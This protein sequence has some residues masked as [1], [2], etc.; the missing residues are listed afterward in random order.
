MIEYPIVCILGRRGSGK[1]LTAVMLAERYHHQGITVFANFETTI[2]HFD[3]DF[4]ELATFPDYLHDCV[5]FMDEMHV[6]SDAYDFWKS[7]VKNIT[8]FVT[9][10]RKRRITLYYITQVYKQVAKRL[11]NQTDYIFQ[12]SQLDYPNKFR[13]DMFDRYQLPPDD[14]ISSFVYD[15]SLYYK[16]YDTNQL[17][18]LETEK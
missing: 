4:S 3:I 9:Q 7:R 12:C 6:G 5:I 1:T 17:I 8:D 14:Y 16:K 2:P 18:L 15:G 13:V 11:R 10:I